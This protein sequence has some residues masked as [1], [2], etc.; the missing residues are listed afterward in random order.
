MRWPTGPSLPVHSSLET[1]ESPTGVIQL[2]AFTHPVTPV[3]GMSLR[4]A[5]AVVSPPPG[6][7]FGTSPTW[8]GSQEHPKLSAV[9]MAK[10]PEAPSGAGGMERGTTRPHMAGPALQARPSQSSGAPEAGAVG[11]APTWNCWPARAGC[12]GLGPGSK[13]TCPAGLCPSSSRMCDFA[14]DCWFPWAP[15]EVA[16]SPPSSTE[17]L[18]QDGGL[19]SEACPQPWGHHHQVAPGMGLV[20]RDTRKRNPAPW[21]SDNHRLPGAHAARH[22]AKLFTGSITCPAPDIRAQRS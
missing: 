10:G 17:D 19:G 21:H 7:G 2:W 15:E 12:Y 5:R 11:S 14:L 20:F 9:G 1:S 3:P 22:S 18:H 8:G 6:C 13:Q 4:L 16:G